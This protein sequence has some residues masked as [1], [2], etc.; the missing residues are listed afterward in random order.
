MNRGMDPFTGLNFKVEIEGICEAH[1]ASCE[2]L[3]SNTEIVEVFEGGENT[4]THKLIG[5]TRFSTIVLRRGLSESIDLWNWYKAVVDHS[6]EPVRKN[7]SIVLL[8]DSGQ[9]KMRWNFYRAWPCRWEGPK[10]DAE[11]GIVSIETL[12]IAHEG[13]E[14]K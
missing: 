3:I 10:F 5:R 2:G 8:D 13:L 12:E 4:K 9:E 11:K 14:L 7:G 1:F 6:S